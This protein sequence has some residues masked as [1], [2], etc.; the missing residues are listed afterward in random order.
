MLTNGHGIVWSGEKDH[1]GQQKTKTKTSDDKVP[2]IPL[3][4]QLNI[5]KGSH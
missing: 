4:P 3:W 2:I 1:Q 5:S